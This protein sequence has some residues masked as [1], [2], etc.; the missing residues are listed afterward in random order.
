MVL[1]KVPERTFVATY[2]FICR[3][4][5][6]LQPDRVY[7]YLVCLEKHIMGNGVHVSWRFEC[8]HSLN[9]LNNPMFTSL[10]PLFGF[11]ATFF[12][13]LSIDYI[14]C[15]ILLRKEKLQCFPCNTYSYC[16]LW[17][18]VFQ[19][20]R[21]PWSWG[22]KVKIDHDRVCGTKAMIF[23]PKRCASFSFLSLKLLL[24]E[25]SYDKIYPMKINQK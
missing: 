16:V 7:K 15:N 12:C 19:Q 9:H 3:T 17:P 8:F 14:C 2:R 5:N 22:G 25:A 4:A 13:Y 10:Q 21:R 24:N 20:R 6:C 1:D 23:R 11:L 18:E